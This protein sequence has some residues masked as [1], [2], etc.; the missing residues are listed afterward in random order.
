MAQPRLLRKRKLALS[1][2]ETVRRYLAPFLPNLH[3]YLTPRKI[4]NILAAEL[5][6]RRRAR[7]VRSRPYV[8]HLEPT[9][10][11]TLRCPLCITGARDL[12]VPT[13]LMKFER[14]TELL[15]RVR[16]DIV[17][18]RMDGVGEPF[19]N[20]EFF[21]ML[22]Y[23][24]ALGMGTAASTN[25]QN[26]KP[27]RMER[28]V[29]TG[30]DYLIVSLDGTTQ[31]VYEQYRVGGDMDKVLR[32]LEAVLEAR[33]RVPGNNLFVEWQFLEF[34]HNAHQADEAKRRAEALGVDRLLI[35]NARP[36]AWQSVLTKEK[37]TTCYWFYKA[38]NVS[39][40]GDLKACCSDG[41]GE[42]FS[43]GNLLS[44]PMEQVWNGP[45]MLALRDLFI[46]PGIYD[47]SLKDSKC[48][49][50]CPIVNAGRRNLGLPEYAATAND[51]PIFGDDWLTAGPKN[52]PAVVE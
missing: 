28:L 23:A 7:V 38:I 20:P 16:D 48:I 44:H 13:G 36:S 9:N 29:R 37:Q 15:S 42:S 50:H 10:A 43:M 45:T 35:T 12:R 4:A 30:L 18:I 33:A 24:H 22:E 14:Y 49:T 39:W 41:L 27:D 2:E 6:M 26:V 1:H 19:L 32:N 40:T 8:L 3:R 25:F 31:E 51:V 34:D 11:C 46:Q 21:A 52:R 17:F 47:S 5:D